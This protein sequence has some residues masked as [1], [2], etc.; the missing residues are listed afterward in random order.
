MQTKMP[1]LSIPHLK[2]VAVIGEGSMAVVYLV[3]DERL[4][5]TRAVKVLARHLLNSEQIRVRFQQEAQ[6]MAALNHPNVVSVLDVGL[7]ESPPFIVMEHVSGGS[8]RSRVDDY[9]CV[10][11]RIA[12]SAIIDVLNALEAAHSA[13]IL[14]RDIKPE[15]LLITQQGSV[16]VSDFGIAH[17]NGADHSFTKTGAVLGTAGFMS[18]EQQR[19]AKG[20]TAQSDLYSVGATLYAIISGDKP[21]GLHVRQA[22]EAALK[23]I[24]DAL[25]EWLTKACAM[26]PEDRFESAA[27]MKAELERSSA[28]LPPDA[29]DTQPLLPVKSTEAAESGGDTEGIGSATLFGRYDGAVKSGN[30]Q[31]QTEWTEDKGKKPLLIVIG[32]AVVLSVIGVLLY[33]S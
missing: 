12:C 4:K 29:E 13:G 23:A 17:V 20:L 25:H 11:P 2:P 30:A 10:A 18:P 16:K 27:E 28:E 26:N 19:S 7:D 5:V 24:P 21:V 1:Q 3:E 22:R 6:T 31:Y 8:L 32:I 15:N 14:H 33:G 9:G